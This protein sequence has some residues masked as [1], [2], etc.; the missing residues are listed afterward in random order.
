M[1]SSLGFD[2]KGASRAPRNNSKYV[3][4]VPRGFSVHVFK[5]PPP[6]SHTPSVKPD[7]NHSHAPANVAWPTPTTHPSRTDSQRK[8]S[9]N[10]PQESRNTLSAYARP[11]ESK[12]TK[13]ARPYGIYPTAIPDTYIY[14]RSV[15]SASDI[16]SSAD[17]SSSSDSDLTESLVSLSIEVSSTRASSSTETLDTILGSNT[18]EIPRRIEATPSR[19]SPPSTGPTPVIPSTELARTRSQ[20]PTSG[21]APA[22]SSH[23]PPSNLSRRPTVETVSDDDS[24]TVVSEEGQVDRLLPDTLGDLPPSTAPG[25]SQQLPAPIAR[26]PD[27][28]LPAHPR[29]REA[30][31]I[32]R[33]SSR[34]AV[35]SPVEYRES[36]GSPPY[37]GDPSLRT[38]P[39]LVGV[40]EAVSAGVAV[41][42]SP[43]PPHLHHG[44]PPHAGILSGGTVVAN[45]RRCVRWTE[46]LVCPS[47]VPRTH[48]RKGWFNRRGDQLWTNDGKYK[49]P[50]VGHEYPPDLVDYP[51]PN[52]GWMNEEGT[53]IDTQHRLIPKPPLRSALKRPKVSSYNLEHLSPSHISPTHS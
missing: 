13:S 44:S 33:S 41:R 15:S 39:G 34:Y 2:S 7:S 24:D 28:R 6:P 49:S 29:L 22:Q 48:R 19:S 32:S 5:N 9:F 12:R 27:E 42:R 17:S 18:A 40:S 51:E 45:T 38:P 1:L 21:R 50:E 46:N 43:P 11:F 26:S 31:A 10:P 20:S 52:A 47:P 3:L 14:E 37:G 16:L 23:S 4:E 25:A 8:H 30:I 35:P 53:R 36:S